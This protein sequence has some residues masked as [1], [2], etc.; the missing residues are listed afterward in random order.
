MNWV[1]RLFTRGR[2]YRDLSDE[3]RQHLDEKVDALVQ[4]GQS[5]DEAVAA[6]RREFGNLT[7]L[8][9]RGREVWQ[10]PTL[11]SL[12]F[13]I[14]YAFRQLR[15]HPSFSLVAILILG[16]GIGANTA[17]FSVI[18][19]LL[20]EALS[21]R[22]PDRLVWVMRA[23]ARGRI[24]RSWSVADYEALQALPALDELTTYEAAFAR[25]SYKLTGDAEPD[26]VAG[27]MVAS[28]TSLPFLGAQPALGRGVHRRR[29]P[30]RERA[31]RR[32]PQPR[33]VAAPR[34]GAAPT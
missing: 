13:D 29:M 6:A 9:E 22:D 32:R 5:R 31:R 20:F 19:T 34:L 24:S 26:R 2:L 15:R 23:D 12:I 21:F 16:L 11:E 14:R 28:P 33:T 10:W 3:M 18:D 4:G 17:V 7:A 8:E 27:V 1:R 30:S 25:S